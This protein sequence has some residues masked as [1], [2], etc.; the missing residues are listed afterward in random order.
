[1]D[2]VPGHVIEN[3]TTVYDWA[4]LGNTQNVYVGGPRGEAAV[5]LAK[6]FGNLQVFVQGSA[7]KVHG[8]ES[9]VPGEVK[10]RVVFMSH[11]LFETSRWKQRSNLPHGLSYA[12]CQVC[13]WSFEGSFSGTLTWG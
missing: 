12:G 9:A 2:H 13:C 11:E 1:M 8:A 7:M 3:I 6:K 5:E 4:S 10:D